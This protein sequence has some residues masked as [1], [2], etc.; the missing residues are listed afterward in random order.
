MAINIMKGFTIT[1]HTITRPSKRLKQTGQ[2]T[3]S[4]GKGLEKWDAYG[5][6]KRMQICTADLEK[7]FTVST[8]D[9]LVQTLPEC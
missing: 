8:R 6:L 3:S 7:C 5:L 1:R 9:D 2:A 4:T